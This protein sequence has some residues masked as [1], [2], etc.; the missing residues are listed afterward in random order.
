MSSRG[1]DPLASSCLRSS[2]RTSSAARVRPRDL[3]VT[4]RA[5]AFAALHRLDFGRMREAGF[6]ER[7]TEMIL[8]ETISE[9]WNFDTLVVDEGQDFRAVLGR[10]LMAAPRTERRGR[11]A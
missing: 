10:S 4:E 9:E 2:S 8:D 1:C 6:W 11:V 3:P 5:D 7:I